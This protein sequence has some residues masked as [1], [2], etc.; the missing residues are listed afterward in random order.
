M[1]VRLVQAAETGA[2]GIRIASIRIDVYLAWCAQHGRDPVEARAGYAA[3]MGLHH[4]EELIAWPP[5]CNQPVP[6]RVGPQ[7]Q[8]VPRRPGCVGAVSGVA[9]EQDVEAALEAMA[10]FDR[11][12]AEAAAQRTTR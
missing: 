2:T 12:A 10:A 4:S 6:V 8:E 7:V 9:Y 3:S 1:Q 5:G 11:D